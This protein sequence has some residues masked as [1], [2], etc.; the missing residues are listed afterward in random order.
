MSKAFLDAYI[1]AALWS[2]TDSE[3]EP[4]DKSV[5]RKD[6]APATL[7]AMTRDCERFEKNNAA[8]LEQAYRQKGYDESQAGHDF[9]LT[10]NGHG[11]G[12]WDG[13][14]E[15]EKLAKKLTDAAHKLG[16][17]ELYVGDDGLVYAGGHERRAN[18]G[19]R[20]TNTF[21]QP[22]QTV[23]YVGNDSSAAG[24]EG[25]IVIPIGADPYQAL[26]QWAIHE[27]AIR[28][29]GSV[30]HWEPEWVDHSDL[31]PIRKLTKGFA[32]YRRDAEGF[33]RPDDTP[34]TGEEHPHHHGGR[35]T[36]APMGEPTLRWSK[37]KNG[38]RQTAHG[39]KGHFD[40]EHS[41][42]IWHLS[43]DGHSIDQYESE[44]AAK[45]AAN[46]LNAMHEAPAGPGEAP[47]GS[48]PLGA[49][50]SEHGLVWK[51][52]ADGVYW[53]NGTGGTYWLLPQPSGDYRLVWTAVGGDQQDLGTFSLAAAYQV[54]ARH[55]PSKQEQAAEPDA[56][57]P[58]AAAGKPRHVHLHLH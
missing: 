10:R 8:L 35:G 58:V 23:R 24:M 30:A 47:I 48:P 29:K 5:S 49:P 6:L 42:K 34:L 33:W 21:L 25:R 54:A 36:N 57:A 16:P 15:D 20:G 22:G 9:W 41:G 4:L 56:P 50:L 19:K 2:S 53:S 31:K 3:G 7:E 46:H 39:R 32:F 51:H 12:F 1:E 55:D 27:R 40:L 17:F 13:R 45:R 26:V 44:E 43:L 14:V 28:Q 38:K 52:R 11:A 18:A 37:T